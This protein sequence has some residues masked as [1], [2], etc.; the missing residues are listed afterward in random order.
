MPDLSQTA[1]E[2][3]AIGIA[4][5]PTVIHGGETMWPA[6]ERWHEKKVLEALEGADE[7]ILDLINQHCSTSDGKFFDSMALSANASAMRYLASKEKIIIMR[8]HGRRVIAS[9]KTQLSE[10]EGVG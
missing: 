1:Q 8:E 10:L 3:K 4:N 7:I 9:L 6:I 5:N 2:I